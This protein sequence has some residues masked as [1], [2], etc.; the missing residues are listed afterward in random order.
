MCGEH[1][2]AITL[3]TGVQQNS[4]F[5]DSGYNLSAS[6]ALRGS[7][8]ADSS[9]ED[10]DARTRYDVKASISVIG[11]SNK[12]SDTAFYSIEKGRLSV[13]PRR[14]WKGEEGY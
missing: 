11:W 8:V 5:E 6:Q 14:F 10:V 2:N 1:L 12:S 9:T 13:T 4:L 3:E 7:E